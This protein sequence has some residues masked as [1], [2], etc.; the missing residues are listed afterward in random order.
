MEPL[1]AGDLLP[2]SNRGVGLRVVVVVVAAAVAEEAVTTGAMASALG[3][4]ERA[5]ASLWGCHPTLQVTGQRD[6]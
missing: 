5:E 3:M 4:T 1:Q 6:C 2:R